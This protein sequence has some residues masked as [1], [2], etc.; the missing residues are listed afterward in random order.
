MR[1]FI[2]LLL[3]AVFISGCGY[4]TGSLLPEHLKTIYV[5]PFRNE[6]ELTD[7]L[8]LD[9]YR[10]RSYRANMET[11]ITEEVIVRFIRDGHLK[12]VDP[13]EADLILSGDLIDYLRQPVRYGADNE[14][15]EEYRLSIVC[16]V[17]IK[18]I[19]KN[20]LLWDEPRIIGDTTY[21]VSGSIAT[22][23]E[24]AVSAAISDLGRRIVNRTIEG[25]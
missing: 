1:N 25:W 17:E 20:V 4:T 18:D 8:T 23:E 13:E 5:Q 10:F 22:S 2:F 11:D 3:I 15:V 21:N 7:E 24:S 19:K 9:Q 12:V 6:I 16:S 14:T